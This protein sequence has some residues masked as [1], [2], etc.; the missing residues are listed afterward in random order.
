ML[1]ARGVYLRIFVVIEWL[2]LRDGLYAH[3]HD[4][5]VYYRLL[6]LFVLQSADRLLKGL[7]LKPLALDELILLVHFLLPG[8]F[9]AFGTLVGLLEL[10]F[11]LF[12]D[13]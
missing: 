13:L 2:G 9:I 8:G 3:L 1:A 7:Y 4:V 12:N 10:T 5:R 6:N 11:Q